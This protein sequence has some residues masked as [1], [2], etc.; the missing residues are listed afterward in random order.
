ME[1]RSRIVEEAGASQELLFCVAIVIH[2]AVL[3]PAPCVSP[4]CKRKVGWY[5]KD[6]SAVLPICFYL[7][8]ARQDKALS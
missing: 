5:V 4:S 1:A 8:Q 2:L 7:P 6:T 3:S